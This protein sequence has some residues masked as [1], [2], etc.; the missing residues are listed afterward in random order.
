MRSPRIFALAWAAGVSLCPFFGAP[1]AQADEYEGFASLDNPGSP[2]SL[3]LS[4]GC[5]SAAIYEDND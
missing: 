5:F 1:P 2:Q 4:G 3:Q